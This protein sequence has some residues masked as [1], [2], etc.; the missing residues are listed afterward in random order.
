MSLLNNNRFITWHITIIVY[1]L[2]CHLSIQKIIS[3]SLCRAASVSIWL[4]VFLIS[5]FNQNHRLKNISIRIYHIYFGG[6]SSWELNIRIILRLW[7]IFFSNIGIWNYLFCL[8]LR[9]TGSS[10]WIFSTPD[11][12]AWLKAKLL[13]FLKTHKL[14]FS[15]LLFDT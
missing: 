7:L 1:W 12:L 8:N 6:H 15:Y 14:S 3:S 5:F 13:I 10:Y 11:K 9:L 2:H 4:L